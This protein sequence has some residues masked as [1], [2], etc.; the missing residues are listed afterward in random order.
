MRSA[1]YAV[2]ALTVVP[3]GAHQR[4]VVSGVTVP[5]A[6]AQVGV[7]V[8]ITNVHVQDGEDHLSLVHVDAGTPDQT[9]LEGLVDTALSKLG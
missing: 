2:I 8:S 9:V 7:P 5:P 6:P 4:G 1:I 3:V